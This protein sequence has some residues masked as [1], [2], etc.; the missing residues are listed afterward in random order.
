M[1]PPGDSVTPRLSVQYRFT[2]YWDDS[3]YYAIPFN[4]LEGVFVFLF[5]VAEYYNRLQMI[6]NC[7]SV[8]N[9]EDGTLAHP[10]GG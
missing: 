1:I 2:A 10:P 8:E 6:V 5:L 7:M 3:Q 9:P 4:E